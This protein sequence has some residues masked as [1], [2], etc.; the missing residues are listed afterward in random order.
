MN[1]ISINFL[2]IIFCKLHKIKLTTAINKFFLFFCLS[3][4]IMLANI[5]ITSIINPLKEYKYN[6]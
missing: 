1:C 3:E 4:I 2:I 6:V 5:G